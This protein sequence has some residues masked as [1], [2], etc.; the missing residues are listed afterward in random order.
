MPAMGRHK[1]RVCL[2]NGRERDDGSY[3]DNDE[4]VIMHRRNCLFLSAVPIAEFG[5]SLD[6]KL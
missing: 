4:S 5:V 1:T 3:I 2:I 6:K